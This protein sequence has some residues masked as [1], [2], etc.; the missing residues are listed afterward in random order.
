MSS[1]GGQ[2]WTCPPGFG[3]RAAQPHRLIKVQFSGQPV[4]GVWMHHLELRSEDDLDAEVA[5]WLHRARH[6]AR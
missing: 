3:T 1:A 2:D 4:P 6:E 5:G